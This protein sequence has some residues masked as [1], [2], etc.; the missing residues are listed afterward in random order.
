MH[1]RILSQT[2]SE[3]GEETTFDVRDV[4]DMLRGVDRDE[5]R[6][7]I[8]SRQIDN[9]TKTYLYDIYSRS[10]DNR[11]LFSK[12]KL[13]KQYLDQEVY[14]DLTCQTYDLLV[15]VLL[16]PEMFFGPLPEQT[17]FDSSD[18]PINHMR[19]HR[20]E[21]QLYLTDLA[22]REDVS[23]EAMLHHHGLLATFALM[24][25][26]RRFEIHLIYYYQ[27]RKDAIIDRVRISVRQTLTQLQG[28]L[29][30]VENRWLCPHVRRR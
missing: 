7:R 28:V 9:L 2:V 22:N 19:Q 24:L 25:L 16:G 23:N 18:I 11:S 29:S 20:L 6:N 27:L 21:M 13:I 5:L 15:G 12:H 3:G 10:P 1:L 8:L 26:L 30:H 17:W 14:P 4:I